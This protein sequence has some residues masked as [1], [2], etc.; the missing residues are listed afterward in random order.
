MQ[1]AVIGSTG[2]NTGRTHR[3]R[4]G[5]KPVRGSTFGKKDHPGS[6][7]YRTGFLKQPLKAIAVR[8]SLDDSVFEEC[9][10]EDGFG[11][12]F[13]CAAHYAGLL[14]YTIEKPA[15]KIHERINMLYRHFAGMIP[16]DQGLNLDMI[17]GRLMWIIY[18]EHKWKGNIFYWMPVR[19]I[20]L[21]SGQIKEIAMSFMNRFIHC[22]GLERF[23][24]SYDCEYLFESASESLTCNDY[25]E[26]ECKVID[27][28]IQS[29]HGGDIA[30]FLDEVYDYKPVDTVR[31]LEEYRP[32]NPLE[33]KLVS[34]FG[35]GLPFI[36]GTS[37]MAYDYD[38]HGD[39]IYG[40]DDEHVALNMII[41][42]VYEVNDFVARELED[43][44]N[45][46]CR[47]AYP[48]EPTTFMILHPDSKLLVPDDYPERFSDWFIEMAGLIDEITDNEQS[49]K[50]NHTFN[51][52][53][54]SA[55]CL[56]I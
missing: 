47:N 9:L 25:S 55:D 21:L 16:K 52:A 53:G 38:P 43:M 5:I 31:A 33:A 19:F 56:H 24:N 39:G 15:G 12:L 54:S 7:L 23:G 48:V 32:V 1:T 8:P 17:D 13:D 2:G 14:G 41:R 20:T 50:K 51:A 4:I 45:Q 29:Y 30:D 37:I 46:Y 49:H 34:C 36:S 35:K 42:Y 26:E 44:T 18:R 10:T 6:R 3:K 27:G 11:S 28:L 40:Y 22:N